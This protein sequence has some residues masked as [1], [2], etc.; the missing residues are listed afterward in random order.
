MKKK[1]YLQQY[2]RIRN[3]MHTWTFSLS[4]KLNWYCKSRTKKTSRKE[5]VGYSLAAGLEEEKERERREK[6]RKR[7]IWERE[8]EERRRRERDISAVL[9]LEKLYTVGKRKWVLAAAV[10]VL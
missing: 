1:N 6:E 8:G 2:K 4:I 7:H 9:A 5:D 3:S 10:D